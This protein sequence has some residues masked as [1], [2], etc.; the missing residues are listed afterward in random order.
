MK[1]NL[2]IL[3]LLLVLIIGCGKDPIPKP[4][5]YFRIHLPE[6]KYEVMEAKCGYFF[7]KPNY[8]KVVFNRGTGIDSCWY[9][10]IVPR[11]NAKF[12]M[13]YLPVENNLQKYSQDAYRMAYE[14]EVKASSIKSTKYYD[15]E[16]NVSG[17]IYDLGGDV[18]TSLQFYMTDS[19]NHFVRG[20]LY[21]ENHPNADSLAP[22]L[23][24]LREDMMHFYETIEWN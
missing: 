22:V 23:E 24:F 20:S 7:E 12:H 9:N 6:K 1:N 18:A 11:L 10:I 4:K 17:I 16:R 2:F 5:G 13:T 3:N 8:A 14:H 19:V 21:F 15:K